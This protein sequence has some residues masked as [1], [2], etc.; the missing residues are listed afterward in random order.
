MDWNLLTMSYNKS[1][2]LWVV[3]TDNMEI[4]VFVFLIELCFASTV[5]PEAWEEQTYRCILF[6]DGIDNVAGKGDMKKM[7]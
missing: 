6:S 4:F 7:T 3:Y 5:R 1:F 2:L